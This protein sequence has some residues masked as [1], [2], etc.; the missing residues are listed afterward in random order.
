NKK[1][2]NKI[3]ELLQKYIPSMSN[4]NVKYIDDFVNEQVIMSSYKNGE[5]ETIS[6]ENRSILNLLY[7]Q[8]YTYNFSLYDENKFYE[9]KSQHI[10]N[11]ILKNYF[12]LICYILNLPL[13]YHIFKSYINLFDTLLDIFK[14]HRNIYYSFN[15]CDISLIC[16]FFLKK[17]IIDD[18]IVNKLFNILNYKID[19][20]LLNTSNQDISSNSNMSNNEKLKLITKKNEYPIPLNDII[21]FLHF[22]NFYNL[23]YDKLCKQL[24]MICFNKYHH[25]N[26]TQQFIFFNSI[27]AMKKKNIMSDLKYILDYFMYDKN[28]EFFLNRNKNIQKESL[29]LLFAN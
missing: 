18:K 5:N 13:K 11:K 24:I 16:T 7:N 26:D 21:I 17:K 12:F 9:N 4:I 25:L 15:I 8:E 14:D 29:G 23:K 2:T 10:M 22:I 19:E 6:N 20:L 1:L 28:M 3:E 27:E